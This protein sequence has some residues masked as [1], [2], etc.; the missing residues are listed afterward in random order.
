MI[1]LGNELL[2]AEPAILSLKLGRLAEVFGDG[3]RTD[4]GLE[5]P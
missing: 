3:F 1:E 2:I 5:L 4:A